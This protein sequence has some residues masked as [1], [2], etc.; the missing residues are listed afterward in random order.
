ME[1]DAGGHKGFTKTIFDFKD[2]TSRQKPYMELDGGGHKGFLKTLFDY[3]D[4]P[5]RQ[6][7]F[8]HV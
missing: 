5:V 4:E 6:K 2:E 7:N 1:F 3:T 8:F